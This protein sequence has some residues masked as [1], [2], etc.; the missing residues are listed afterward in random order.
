[1]KALN[2]LKNAFLKKIGRPCTI[3]QKQW[4]ILQSQNIGRFNQA[5]WSD[6]RVAE[7]ARLESV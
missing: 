7:E 3:I 6:A 1:M 5:I 2:V 4:L